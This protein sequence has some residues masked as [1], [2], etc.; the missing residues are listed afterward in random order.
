MLTVHFFFQTLTLPTALQAWHPLVPAQPFLGTFEKLWKMTI[1]FV[2]SVC[3]SVSMERL[4]SHWK[5][6]HE[7]WYLR[8][9]W[10]FLTKIQVSLKS[11]KNKG[12]GMWRPISLFIIFCSLLLRM[13]NVSD[14]IIEKI[15]THILH[16]VTFFW[17]LCCLW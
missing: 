7:I 14:K 17:N 9:F 5:D 6:F 11:D 16:S 2:I 15:K 10:K 12:Y 8:V 13:R 3:T 1:S 4:G